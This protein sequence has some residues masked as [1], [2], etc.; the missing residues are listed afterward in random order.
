MHD[1]IR[2][3]RVRRRGVACTLGLLLL[4]LTQPLAV[5][6]QQ[7]TTRDPRD[8]THAQTQAPFFTRK[9]AYLAG[10]FAAATVLMFPLD[11]RAAQE[12]QE[13]ETQTNRFF[14]NASTGVEVIASPGAYVIGGSLY[15]IGKLAHWDRVADLGSHGTEA[16]LVGDGLTF[17]LK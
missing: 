11:K 12:L 10:G 17:A 5:I 1:H 4:P 13:P 8:T 7:P 2:L 16:V 6:A 9:D 3:K 15:A 14:K